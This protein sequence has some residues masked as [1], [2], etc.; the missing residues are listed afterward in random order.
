MCVWVW[1]WKCDF[2]CLSHRRR[3]LRIFI[4]RWSSCPHYII[5]GN[6]HTQIFS[7]D[8]RCTHTYPPLVA[9]FSMWTNLVCLCPQRSCLR[10]YAIWYYSDM[11]SKSNS[12]KC[13]FNCDRFILILTRVCACL[14]FHATHA[15]VQKWWKKQKE[16][17]KNVWKLKWVHH[18]FQCVHRQTIETTSRDMPHSSAFYDFYFIQIELLRRSVKR[19][20]FADF[21]DARIIEKKLEQHIRS[22]IRNES[23]N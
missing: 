9:F 5:R 21:F 13:W 20:K 12:S 22:V 3:R 17:K 11:Q 8:R 1:K 18:Q 16:T 15:N 4:E 19:T 23:T 7:I 10:K 2:V 6:I 14:R